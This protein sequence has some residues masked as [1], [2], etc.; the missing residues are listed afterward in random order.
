VER[1]GLP[2][3]VVTGFIR[4]IKLRSFEFTDSPLNR[5]VDPIKNEQKRRSKMEFE[6]D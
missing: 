5:R 4:L 2:R 6:E 1:S 3:T